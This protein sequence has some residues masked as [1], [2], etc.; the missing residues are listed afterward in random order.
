M[1]ERISNNN[2]HTITDEKL[3]EKLYKDISRRELFFLYP[4]MS[5]RSG[6]HEYSIKNRK[7][8]FSKALGISPA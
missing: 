7:R 6:I 8:M 2:Q 5:T 4:I 3:Q 1:I